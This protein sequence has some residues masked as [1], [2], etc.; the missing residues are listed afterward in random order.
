MCANLCLEAKLLFYKT[1]NSIVSVNFSEYL[2]RLTTRT[3]GHQLKFLTISTR[4]NTFY[5]SFLPRTIHL[6]NSLPDNIVILPNIRTYCT[7]NWYALT[8]KLIFCIIITHL[9][10]QYKDLFA[11]QLFCIHTP[12]LSQI[13]VCFQPS[14]FWPK[15]T[16]W[17][18]CFLSHMFDCLTLTLTQS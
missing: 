8:L 7:K 12:M 10:T 5:H 1:I 9:Y 16:L 17:H 4:A 13:I 2:Q 11:T 6:R 14:Y 18:T 3:R 15:S